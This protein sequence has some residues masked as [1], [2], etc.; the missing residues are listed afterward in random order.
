MNKSDNTEGSYTQVP[1]LRLIDFG[2]ARYVTDVINLPNST[3]KL[4]ET[5]NESIKDY[6]ISNQTSLVTVGSPEFSAPEIITQQNFGTEADLWS[7]GALIYVL[8]R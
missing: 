4:E 8:V 6:F 3:E 2:S 5:I 1:L 7:L